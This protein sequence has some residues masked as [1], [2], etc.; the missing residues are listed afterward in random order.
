MKT[1]IDNNNMRK[2][3]STLRSAH[4]SFEISGLYSSI[5]LVG[6]VNAPMALQSFDQEVYINVKQSTLHTSNCE[7]FILRF[8]YRYLKLT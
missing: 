2:Y 5:E 6:L 8:Y 3:L 7:V 1:L 4:E